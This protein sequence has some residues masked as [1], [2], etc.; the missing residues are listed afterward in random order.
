MY[1]LQQ[2]NPLNFYETF[3]YNDIKDKTTF[4]AIF[5]ILIFNS[6]MFCSFP[7]YLQ[8]KRS[9]SSWLINR[10]RVMYRMRETQE[11]LCI[12]EMRNGSLFSD[13]NNCTEKTEQDNR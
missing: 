8:K 5:I 4:A 1:L 3:G 10:K 13:D 6:C 12:A 11:N 2:Q 7:F 9:F